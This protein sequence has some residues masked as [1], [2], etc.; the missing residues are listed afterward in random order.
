M[1]L[2]SVPRLTHQLAKVM[3]QLHSFNDEKYTCVNILFTPHLVVGNGI[4]TRGEE[5]AKRGNGCKKG[6]ELQEVNKWPKEI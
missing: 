5:V 6:P 2:L 3:T 4:Q 1:D